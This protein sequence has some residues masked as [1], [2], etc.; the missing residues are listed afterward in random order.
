MVP[1]S[2]TPVDSL[3]ICLAGTTPYLSTSSITKNI[4][5]T[6]TPPYEHILTWFSSLAGHISYLTQDRK[7]KINSELVTASRST[8]K[9]TKCP[10][11][12]FSAIPHLSCLSLLLFFFFVAP[13]TPG[14]NLSVHWFS[15]FHLANYCGLPHR[16]FITHGV[17]KHRACHRVGV[18]CVCII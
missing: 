1:G 14:N 15:V 6:I 12:G 7:W 11:N 10:W 2:V 16:L 9:A 13:S 18:L 17:S 8:E 4:K 3:C 5:G